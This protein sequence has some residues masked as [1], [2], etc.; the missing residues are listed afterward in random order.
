[1]TMR[2]SKILMP[3]A[4][5]LLYFIAVVGFSATG[6]EH[7]DSEKA[8]LR[9]LEYERKWIDDAEVDE[10]KVMD[11]GVISHDEADAFNEEQE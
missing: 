6:D 5:V 8:K 9:G 10:E 7:H 11:P 3:L 2:A 4:T 1:M